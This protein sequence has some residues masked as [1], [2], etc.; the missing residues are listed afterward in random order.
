MPAG[1]DKTGT[2]RKTNRK[3]TI[4]AALLALSIA[5]ILGTACSPPGTENIAPAAGTAQMLNAVPAFSGEPEAALETAGPEGVGTAGTGHPEGAR[6]EMAGVCMPD[7]LRVSGHGT[8]EGIP[9]T[10][11]MWASVTKT[12]HDVSGI[13]LEVNGA[14]QTIVEAAVENGVSREDISTTRFSLRPNQVYDHDLRDF[15]D[16]GM[17]V[18]RDIKLKIR[19]L[20][21]AS[22][23]AGNILDAAVAIREVKTSIN[24]LDF[25]IEDDLGL[26]SRAMEEAVLNLRLRAGI[27]AEAAGRKVSRMARIQTGTAP[28]RI[29]RIFSKGPFLEAASAERSFAPSIPLEGGTRTIQASVSGTFILEPDPNGEMETCI[30]D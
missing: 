2:M 23:A 6:D 25:T 28:A 17:V 5:V 16:E 20:T 19:D 7:T 18:S 21:T 3:N 13:I 30:R 26:R 10:L 29:D 22:Q 14:T 9:D 27:M 8:A 24:G 15:R 1:I 11:Q 12:G 4:G